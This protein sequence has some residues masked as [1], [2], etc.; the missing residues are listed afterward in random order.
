MLRETLENE[1]L[2]R[3]LRPTKHSASLLLRRVIPE[4]EWPILPAG[5]PFLCYFSLA[6]VKDFR[7]HRAIHVLERGVPGAPMIFRQGGGLLTIQIQ[8]PPMKLIVLALA[9][10][11]LASCAS[12]P[13]PA[14]SVSTSSGYVTQAK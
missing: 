6:I 8:N 13:N 10:A 5:Y 3:V 12:K 4:L 7:L 11:A 1:G 2:Q 9:A 14:P